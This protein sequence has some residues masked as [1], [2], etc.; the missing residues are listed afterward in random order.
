MASVGKQTVA[1]AASTRGAPLEMYAGEWSLIQ[2]ETCNTNNRPGEWRRRSREWYE[3]APPLASRCRAVSLGIESV[4]LRAFSW[5]L[6]N[7][8]NHT[9]IICLSCTLHRASGRKKARLR[10]ARH[11]YE[12]YINF[13]NAHDLNSLHESRFWLF[14][15]ICHTLSITLAWQLLLYDYKL[16]HTVVPSK[17]DFPF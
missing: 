11:G 8:S 5:S 4:K 7:W 10:Q 9:A 14:R 6:A 1:E 13:N 17:S 16:W 12:Q 2:R 3:R 15:C